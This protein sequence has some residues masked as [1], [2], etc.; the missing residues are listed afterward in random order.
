MHRIFSFLLL[1]ALLVIGATACSGSKSYDPATTVDDIESLIY[2]GDFDAARSMA[3]KLC[4]D[5][6]VTLSTRQLCRLSI[7]YMKFSDIFDT[8]I[9]TTLATRC[10]RLAINTNADSANAFYETLPLDESRHVDLMSKLEPLLSTDRNAYI[11]EDTDID[12]EYL[13]T[14][15]SDQ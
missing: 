4:A 13:I 14:E 1:S 15:S 2:A 5:T 3:D 11:D 10:Y 8:D 12:P 7:A 9:N 6:T